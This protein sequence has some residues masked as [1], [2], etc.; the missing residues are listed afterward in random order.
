VQAAVNLARI[1]GDAVDDLDR[2]A[3]VLPAQQADATAFGAKIDGDEGAG[4]RRGEWPGCHCVASV[5]NAWY[6]GELAD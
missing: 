4:V 3:S 5:L 1:V 2:G 6:A